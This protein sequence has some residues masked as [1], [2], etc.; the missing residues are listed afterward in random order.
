MGHLRVRVGEAVRIN[1]TTTFSAAAR[2]E[3]PLLEIGDHSYV[4]Y[5]VTIAIGTKVSIGRH[6]LIA[7]RVFLCSD[8]GHPLDPQARRT[9]PGTGKGTI[10]IGDDVW[11]GDGAIVLKD[12]RI[13][14]GAVVAAGS[15]V[16]DDVPPYSVVAGNPAR[17]VKELPRPNVMV[18]RSAR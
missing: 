15:V 9:E 10:E 1:G 18:V 7:N 16:T 6:V 13:G 17:I 2:A 14:D 3:H 5:Q 11:I 12:L 4:G 8:D